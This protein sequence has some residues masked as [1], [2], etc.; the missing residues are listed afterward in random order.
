M[1]APRATEE[2]DKLFGLN[3]PAHLFAKLCWEVRELRLAISRRHSIGF[4]MLNEP[5]FHVFNCAVSAWHLRDW[6]WNS[7]SELQRVEACKMLGSRATRDSFFE[8]ID[9]RFRAIHI[10]GQIAN[11][12][13]HLSL[14]PKFE[15][16]T[17][18]TKVNW[19]TE[20]CTTGTP[21]SAP[22]D[23]YR[24]HLVVLDNGAERS[25]IEVFEMA[26]TNWQ[27]MLSALWLIEGSM[28][29]F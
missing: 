4:A 7:L 11:G 9:R 20:T 25:V 18:Q 17:V 14:W 24:D 16:P 3:E 8:T 1:F 6:V 19:E 27:G 21:C 5:A 12:S 22:L 13:K 28:A 23:N 26:I 2:D 10:C 15:D 29:D